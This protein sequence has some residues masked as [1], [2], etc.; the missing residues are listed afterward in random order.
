MA[1]GSGQEVCFHGESGRDH[2]GL[3][4]GPGRAQDRTQARV[5]MAPPRDSNRPLGLSEMWHHELPEMKAEIV[6]VLRH[7]RPPTGV[8]RALWAGVSPGVSDGVSSKVRVSDGVSGGVSP[9]F[10]GPRSP[11]C[12]KS[13]PRVSPECP[14]TFWTLRGQSR[15]TFWTLWSGGPKGPWGHPPGHSVGHPDFRGHSVRLPGTLGP[16]GR[17][18]LL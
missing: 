17:E 8:S 4:M 12:P 15:D 9:G 7:R 5:W 16:K 11:E 2:L 14:G 3:G 13:V 1:S 10:F 6:V 18:R